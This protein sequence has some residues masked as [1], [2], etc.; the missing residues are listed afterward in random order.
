MQNIIYDRFKKVAEVQIIPD[1]IIHEKAPHARV[2]GRKYNICFSV[3]AAQRSERNFGNA[4][5][6]KVWYA[7]KG[8]DDAKR[9]ARIKFTSPEYVSHTRTKDYKPQW[10]LDRDSKIMMYNYLITPLSKALM[11]NK[12]Y[13]S[14]KFIDFY[15]LDIDLNA[16]TV[17]QYL[18][19]LLDVLATGKA[20]SIQIDTEMANNF[21]A[22]SYSSNNQITA[23]FIPV[24]YPMPNYLNLRGE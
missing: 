5:Y 22:R 12:S 23:D 19:L 8:D 4:A 13:V 1:N 20:A 14:P 21:I 17:Y 7:N 6:F 16:F 3:D 2:A 9:I 10:M 15:K 11:N 18:I 24:N